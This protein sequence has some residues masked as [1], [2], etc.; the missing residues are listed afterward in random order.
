MK[1]LY[2]NFDRGIPVLG[3]K[4]ASVHVREFVRGAAS[5]GHETLLVCCTLGSG[6]ARPPADMV[7]IPLAHTAEEIAAL[8]QE[9]GLSHEETDGTV[10]MRELERLA[11][12]RTVT[13]RVLRV[14]EEKDF[15]PDFIYE[16]HA[17]FSSAGAHIAARLRC[18]RV[19]EVNAPLA[20]EQKRFRGLRL[21]SLAR[22]MEAQSFRT[23]TALIAV[24]ESV[25]RYV[26]EL[27]GCLASRAHVLPNGVDLAR[28]EAGDP[29][30][31]RI[32][33]EIGV[34]AQTTVIGFVGSFKPWHGTD[35]LFEVFRELAGAHRVHLLAVGEGP[36]RDGFQA[37]VAG[38]P[39]RASVTMPGRVPHEQI[40][41]WTSAADII[42]APYRRAADFYFSPLKV[43]EALACARPVVAPRI[44]QLCEL[45]EDGRTGL[46]YEPDDSPGCRRAIEMLLKEPARRA[47]MGRA[48]RAS[49]AERGWEHIVERV[50]ALA[51]PR[52]IGASA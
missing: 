39:C 5:L 13:A 17:L 22:D 47:A 34:D 16:R 20:D 30:G 35:V 6:N 12:D 43:I 41:A 38:A 42:V 24:S 9:F 37:R 28:F 52:A 15:R 23:A 19:L 21:E 10:A 51:D 7:E 2:L 11:Y 46:L 31:V 18:P 8:R 40:P 32:R 26:Q 45:I 1:I 49:V 27:D 14:L 50:V 48:A 36:E 33:R 4:G 25:K 29:E 3:D 44:G